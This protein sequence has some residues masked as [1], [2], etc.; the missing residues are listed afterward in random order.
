M[1][2]Q[3][4]QATL[5]SW[6]ALQDQFNV[7]LTQLTSLSNTLSTYS[8][9][10]Q[11]TV[12]YPLPNFPSVTESG[13]LTTLLRKKNLPSVDEWIESG[14]EASK[15]TLIKQDDDFCRWALDVVDRRRDE[16]EWTGFRTRKQIEEGMSTVDGMTK[17]EENGKGWSMDEI[18]IYLSRG[19]ITHNTP[20]TT[21]NNNAI[22]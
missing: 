15:N 11:R 9:L 3:I 13:L 1:Q 6:P 14:S 20:N 16:H 8:E 2:G 4:Q 19:E 17:K 5:P 18:L 7:I 22:L 12:A 10:L 21:T